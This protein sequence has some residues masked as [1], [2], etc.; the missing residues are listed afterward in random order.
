MACP[1]VVGVPNYAPAGGGLGANSTDTAWASTRSSWPGKCLAV[2]LAKGRRA[3]R[4]NAARAQFIHE[5]AHRQPRCDIVMGIDFTARIEH[6]R[7]FCERGGRQ[8]NVG[9]NDKIA[10]VGFGGDFV[11]GGVKA[12][13]HLDGADVIG[14]R[15]TQRFVGDQRQADFQPLRMPGTEFP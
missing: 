10:G 13:G 4:L 6:A 15:R 9:G 3:A 1:F 14:A 12:G 8:R 2:A 5:F 11:V 7:A